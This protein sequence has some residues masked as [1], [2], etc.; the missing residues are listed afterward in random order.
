MRLLDAYEMAYYRN[1]T[2]SSWLTGA[3]N[4]EAYTKALSNSNRT[5]KS[6]PVME[7]SDWQDPFKKKQEE[8]CCDNLDEELLRQQQLGNDWLFSR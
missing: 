4:F 6:D 1:I 7:Y 5:K 3:R 8:V 2:Y